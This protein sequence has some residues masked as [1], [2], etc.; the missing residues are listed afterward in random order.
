M[1]ELSKSQF[2]DD[3][4]L[5]YRAMKA[6]ALGRIIGMNRELSWLVFDVILPLI[7]VM[8]YAYVYKTLNTPR[9]FIGYVI[10]GGAM[11]GFWMNVL[12]GMASQFYWERERGQL[13]HI[14]IAPISRVSILLGMAIGGIYTTGLRSLFTFIFGIWIFRIPVH[15][16]S[17]PLLIVTFIVT[18][19]SLYGLGMLG[20]S[21]FLLFGRDVFHLSNLLQEP[22][23]LISGI[24]FPVKSIGM[25]LAVIASI[26]PVTLG[27]DALRQ[28]IFTNIDFKGLFPVWTEILILFFLGIIYLFLS[29]KAINYMELRARKEGRLTLRWQ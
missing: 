18:L 22:V 13:E 7:S 10:L 3:L 29:I 25:T 14:L 8:A 17:W 6:R 11:T 27:L 1:T 16:T 15:V 20:S 19:V 28:I 4:T 26:I 2:I 9:A 5:N 24:Y 12:W 23:Y 21:V